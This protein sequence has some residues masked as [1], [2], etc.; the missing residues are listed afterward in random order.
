MGK[1]NS[2]L[3]KFLPKNIIAKW[4]RIMKIIFTK[5]IDT[6]TPE[7]REQKRQ[8]AITLTALIASF[9]KII[10]LLIPFITVKATKKYLG[11]DIYGLWS[12]V[13]SFF[14]VFAFAD[15]GLG[16]GLQTNLSKATGKDNNEEECKRLISSTF[17]M[18][19]SVAG[20]IIFLFL[21]CYFFVDWAS[22]VNATSPEAIALA[23]PVFLAIVIPK[24]IDIPI[25]LTQRTQVALQEGYNYYA[26]SILGSILSIVSVYL[27][28]Y[29][30]APKVVMILCSAAIPTII[31]FFNFI[32]YFC[33]SNRRT[34]FPRF[35][36]FNWNTCKWMLGT[37][38]GFLII[39]ILMNFGLSNMDSF[40][41][42]NVDNLAMAG[43]YSICLKVSMVINIIANMFGLS[44]WGVYGEA[45]ARGD[46]K[47][48]KKSVFNRAM[49]MLG[50]T[51]FATLCG[52]ILAPIAFKIIVGNDF[53]YNP[54]TLLGMFLLQC[55][56]AFVN[57]FFM[58][59][60]GTGK[61]KKQILA[62][63]I[64]T[65]VSFVLKLTLSPILGVDI[66]PWI[67]T[68]SLVIIIFPI[69][70]SESLKIIKEYEK[71]D[72]KIKYVIAL[73]PYGTVYDHCYNDL[74]ADENIELIKD[75][76]SFKSKIMRKIYQKHMSQ[77]RKLPFRNIWNGGYLK[78]RFNKE[79]N[80]IFVLY[81][82]ND[83]VLQYG[84]I[85][86]L[87]KKYKNAKFVLY[88]TDLVQTKIKNDKQ[89]SVV[90]QFDLVISF[91]KKDCEQYGF[92]YN[93][94]VYSAPKNIDKE[95]CLIDVYFCGRAKDRLHE[96]MKVFTYL[97]TLNL[98]CLF[99]IRDVPK[100]ERVEIEG[101]KYLDG[102]MPYEENIE[103]I[104]KSKCLLEV[105]QENGVG[106]T[107]RTCEAVAFN[108]KIITD[109]ISIKDAD[110]YTEKMIYIF[111]KNDINIDS[112]FFNSL[113]Y[114]YLDNNYFS[115]R[116]LINKISEVLIN[117]RR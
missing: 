98:K 18:L 7:G 78:N 50:L 88:F 100:E 57:P 26:W 44:L 63:G 59:L 15:L 55:C 47:Y 116:K 77:K 102:F 65:P 113:N 37:G 51:L 91:D 39:H 84:L 117:E 35:K 75:L 8:K 13:N 96:I 29:L 46:V 6:S 21:G 106:Y 87:R 104:K 108:K 68:I 32:Y 85:K 69:I 62:Y 9:A 41:V 114:N 36:Y 22:L 105:M 58:V 16:S 99:L 42:G 60:N 83:N 30:N 52:M 4:K 49:L 10:A 80:I 53:K 86:R 112:D 38:V 25:A 74:A 94:L 90:N 93:P 12:S 92:T 31:A 79:D 71:S 73:P 27:N 3:S 33:F 56:F 48:V 107:L 109:N 40:I 34:F 81:Y 76:I 17:I 2:M 14:A 115:P 20:I 64:F 54:L 101:L 24:L 66:L 5:N 95:E 97:R 111:D 1:S 43:D 70:I 19:F 110:F 82:L 72:G 67:T 61:I 103:Y 11:D 89:L 23:G 45:L 28:V